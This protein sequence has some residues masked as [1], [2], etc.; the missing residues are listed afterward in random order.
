MTKLS[1]SP[2]S[3]N[4]GIL[5][6]LGPLEVNVVLDI[7]SLPPLCHRVFKKLYTIR[8]AQDKRANNKHRSLDK[9]HKH[10]HTLL[11]TTHS[12]PLLLLLLLLFI[13]S[14]AIGNIP[15]WLWLLLYFHTQT[16]LTLSTLSS[17]FTAKLL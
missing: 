4:L 5:R 12:S 10:S 13:V 8:Y 1:I 11:V 6:S 9:T 3:V 7:P 16:L 17:C 2:S 14:I 15:F